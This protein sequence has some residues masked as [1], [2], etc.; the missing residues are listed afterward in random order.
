[1]S[2]STDDKQKPK[3][4]GDQILARAQAPKPTVTVSTKD[5]KTGQ[6]VQR[7]DLYIGTAGTKQADLAIA[8]RQLATGQGIGDPNN[9]RRAEY[10]KTVEGA[11][12][13]S[14]AFQEGL[15]RNTGDK[16]IKAAE[17]RVEAERQYY[18]EQPTQPLTAGQRQ[19]DG[20]RITS[21]R[22]QRPRPPK[23][24]DIQARLP[25]RY[26]SESYRQRVEEQRRQERDLPFDAYRQAQ[27]RARAEGLDV[28]D[29]RTR[30]DR[31]TGEGYAS[32]DLVKERQANQPNAQIFGTTIVGG[33]PEDTAGRTVEVAPEDYD[34]INRAQERAN[35]LVDAYNA[36]PDQEAP[37][38]LTQQE[39]ALFKKYGIDNP[40]IAISKTKVETRMQRRLQDAEIQRYKD[41]L[42]EKGYSTIVSIDEQGYRTYTPV[43]R[44]PEQQT[45]NKAPSP[46]DPIADLGKGIL[47]EAENAAKGLVAG[48]EG[49]RDVWFRQA[50][51]TVYDK[52]GN[53]VSTT[54]PKEPDYA[55]GVET[56]V[57]GLS[58]RA[59]Y[60]QVNKGKTDVTLGD[61]QKVGEN[62]LANPAYA[63]GNL[64]FSAATWFGP[65]AGAKVTKIAKVGGSKV[66]PAFAQV[67]SK[68]ESAS[69]AK[70]F[71]RVEKEF[72]P[73]L[74]ASKPTLRKKTENVNLDRVI[75]QEKYLEESDL[76]Q[77]RI[78][79]GKIDIGL[80]GQVTPYPL[81]RYGKGK[82][83]MFSSTPDLETYLG[84]EAGVTKYTSP[85]AKV[86]DFEVETGLLRS[87]DVPETTVTDLG[88]TLAK[89]PIDDLVRT[90]A[91]SPK[92]DT[93]IRVPKSADTEAEAL[94]TAGFKPEKPITIKKKPSSLRSGNIYVRR[95]QAGE[96]IYFRQMFKKP[97]PVELVRLPSGKEIPVILQMFDATLLTSETFRLGR[98][99]RPGQL[100]KLLRTDAGFSQFT[101]RS[102]PEVTRIPRSDTGRP[103]R[104]FSYGPEVSQK[105][106]QEERKLSA[107]EIEK[108][109]AF[110]KELEKFRKS[111]S[112]VATAS[113]R[114]TDASR[115]TAGLSLD[116]YG[117]SGYASRAASVIAGSLGLG[118][119][120]GAERKK[121]RTRV[122][123]EIERITF[124]PAYKGSQIENYLSSFSIKPF[125]T[126][127]TIENIRDEFAFDT[128]TSQSTRQQTKL[129]NRFT[130]AFGFKDLVGESQKAIVGLR[131][132]FSSAL[133]EATGVTFDV[134]SVPK[135]PTLQVPLPFPFGGFDFDIPIGGRP[136][137]VK[138]GRRNYRMNEVYDFIFASSDR[139]FL[140]GYG[141]DDYGAVEAL[142]QP[143]RRKMGGYD[144]TKAF[145]EEYG[146]GTRKSRS[147][148]KSRRR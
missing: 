83:E 144:F 116:G 8:K 11:G 110:D 39:R 99:G 137:R 21:V 47:A 135:I 145:T 114:S 32:Y 17:A 49:L 93:I 34:A 115:I 132:G 76:P 88:T 140:P 118:G 90:K 62:I 70:T 79:E 13:K 50:P 96:T 80:E 77:L 33:P 142:L 136:R 64:A 19:P 56:D 148:K 75:N 87:Q 43:G 41:E 55:A 146:F 27:A 103:A 12:V 105:A 100:G 48:F 35:Q 69:D 51:R 117:F 123:T 106:V 16:A 1:M 143:G 113:K 107:A 2:A 108:I 74:E 91:A 78:G 28:I 92:P 73:Y 36:N 104:P 44:G 25:E 68:L 58:I 9:E 42:K 67:S 120:T 101:G 94:R 29:F 52:E 102:A 59:G 23:E 134:P 95:E 45:V 26:Q 14:R 3:S 54:K 24:E 30:I 89:D 38:R 65:T 139:E 131:P 15:R 119:A 40:E 81:G 53:V 122:D 31:E 20:S 86:D 57:I 130:E 18:R 61:Y 112:T 124:P 82:I 22:G 141:V 6:A 66:R 5:R 121:S 125:Q 4:I 97:V 7:Q 111:A 147:K 10:L 60:E 133:R 72:Q 63:A 71:A 98:F 109:I 129:E 46:S 126:N 85:V 138:I 84:K 128:V 37:F 127:S